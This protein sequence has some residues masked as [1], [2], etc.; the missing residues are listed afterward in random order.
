MRFVVEIL[1]GKMLG[2]MKLDIFGGI[3]MQNNLL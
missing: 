3:R 2:K 1:R